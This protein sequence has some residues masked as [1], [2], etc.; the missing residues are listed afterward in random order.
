MPHSVNVSRCGEKYGER[1][2]AARRRAGF[3]TQSALAQALG[4]S[5]STI[6]RHERLARPPVGYM[7]LEVA[8]CTGVSLWW[9]L[10]GDGRPKTVAGSVPVAP[11]ES[12]LPHPEGSLQELADVESL[13]G[14]VANVE[15]SDAAFAVEVIDESMSPVYYPGDIAVVDPVRE[16][17]PGCEALVRVDEGVVIRQLVSLWGSEFSFAPF[18]N[19]YPICAGKKADILGR[20]VEHVR[21]PQLLPSSGL[22]V[23][24]AREKATCL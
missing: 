22:I 14:V 9:L 1:I 11:P 2:K 13:R 18:N 24:S 15:V 8:L 6:A 17:S 5:M 12:F 19:F 7:P 3:Q 21:F 16:P 23:P 10:Y 4:M 20:I